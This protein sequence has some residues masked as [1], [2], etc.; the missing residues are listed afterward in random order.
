MAVIYCNYYVKPLTIHVPTVQSEVFMYS[1]ATVPD[2]Q[3]EEDKIAVSS[4]LPLVEY[5]DTEDNLYPTTPPDSQCDVNIDSFEVVDTWEGDEQADEA[6]DGRAMEEPGTKE[7]AEQAGDTPCKKPSLD[8]EQ[9]S[10][11]EFAAMLLEG[12]GTCCQVLSIPNFRGVSF[13]FSC[14]NKLI[15][16]SSVAAK[17]CT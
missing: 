12:E 14:N 10:D 13:W 8:T 3:A 9:D 5:Q 17:S 2:S 6:I 7:E 16:F 1:Q 4:G 15:Q 11:D